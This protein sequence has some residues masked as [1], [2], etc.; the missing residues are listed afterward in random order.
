MQSKCLF[1]GYVTPNGPAFERLGMILPTSLCAG[2]VARMAV[3][4]LNGNKEKD[5]GVDRFVT[6][7]HTEGCGASS[8][9]SEELFMRTMYGH[10]VHPNVKSVLLLE[11]GC[12]K[13]HNDYF[14]NYFSQFNMKVD[15][16]GWASIQLG[17][18]I[19]KTLEQIEGWFDNA[20]QGAAGELQGYNLEAIKIG[21]LIDR[22]SPEHLQA[23]AASVITDLVDNGA[24]VILPIAEGHQHPLLALLGIHDSEKTLAYGQHSSIS[25]LHLMNTPSFNWQEMITGLGATGVHIMLYFG[26]DLARPGHPFIPLVQIPAEIQE[27]VSPS[28]TGVHQILPLIT[29]TLTGAHIPL[30]MELGNLDFQITRGLYGISL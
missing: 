23:A 8:G 2:Q 5:F 18:G 17:G 7:V 1:E 12:E 24:S 6:L 22:N 3:E 20:S 16:F 11:H 27:R 15:A 9:S 25:G 19:Q 29:D 30:R 21:L 28:L 14:R 10:V 26:E 4:Q 13:T